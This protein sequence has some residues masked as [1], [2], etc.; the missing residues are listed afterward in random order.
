MSDK[1][2][3]HI[4]HLHRSPNS[5][6]ENNKLL[7]QL[8]LNTSLIG[9]KLLILG[10]FNF[11]TIHWD[12]LST[13]HL[14]N[15]CP[16]EFIAA[17]QD[18]LLF[19]YVQSP[20]HTRP[21][22]KPTLVDLIFSQ[23]DQTITNMTTRAPLGKS[24]HKVLRFHYTVDNNLKDERRRRYLYDRAN[25]DDMKLELQRIDW[26]EVFY[27]SSSLNVKEIINNLISKFVPIQKH[28][29]KKNKSV[30]M[31]KLILKI[32]VKKRTYHRFLKT[33]DQHDYQMY[34]TY[35]NQSKNACR[36]AVADYEKSLSIEVK[37]KPKAF[38]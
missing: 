10:D 22:Q 5:S 27:N 19:Q 6:S 35:R 15:H 31:N 2:S 3:L 8:I 20:T 33:R 16:S 9:G 21:N 13:P 24:H 25:Y 23:E 7:T 11:P 32:K 4:L 18:A 30:W 36:K 26:Y 38:L 1:T 12:N 37:S 29:P 28:T 17:T 34:A 14:S